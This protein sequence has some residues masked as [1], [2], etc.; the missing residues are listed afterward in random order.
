MAGLFAAG[1]YEKFV[2]DDEEEVGIVLLLEFPEEPIFDAI[3]S[4]A[5]ERILGGD[6]VLASAILTPD[7]G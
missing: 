3:Q 2:V 1:G 6:F 7:I 4:A 5:C